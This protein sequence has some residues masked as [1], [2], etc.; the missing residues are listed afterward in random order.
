MTRAKRR[1]AVEQQEVDKVCNELIESGEK[2]K[3][4]VVRDRIGGSLSTISKMVDHWEA[5]RPAPKATII[6]MPDSINKAMQRATAEIWETASTL[7]GETVERIQSETSTAV[8]QAKEEVSEYAEEIE[9]LENE[10]LNAQEELEEQAT[11]IKEGD[12]RL[13]EML[14]QQAS[15]QSR[16]DEQRTELETAKADYKSLQSELLTTIERIQKEAATERETLQCQLIEIAKSQAK[17]K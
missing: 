11:A 15:L 13:T 12:T 14:T 1:E 16:Y 10:L 8:N 7:A 17:K 5:N 3:K 2:V 9:R 6:A 4:T